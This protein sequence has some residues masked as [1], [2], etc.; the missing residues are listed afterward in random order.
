MYLSTFLIR[1]TS[2]VHNVSACG[3]KYF[4]EVIA[5]LIVHREYT[6]ALWYPAYQLHIC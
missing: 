3:A 1:F 6:N 2:K 5:N 4:L